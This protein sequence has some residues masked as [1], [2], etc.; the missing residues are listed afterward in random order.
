[1]FVMFPDKD[2]RLTP[3]LQSVSELHESLASFYNH[4]LKDNKLMEEQN[5][6]YPLGLR[7]FQ[8]SAAVTLQN[9]LIE[10]QAQMKVN[11][12]KYKRAVTAGLTEKVV[13]NCI[14]HKSMQLSA[15]TK[16]LR[17]TL[18]IML[19]VA[20]SEQAAIEFTKLCTREYVDS[21]N[22]E[23]MFSALAELAKNLGITSKYPN[24]FL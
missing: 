2:F 9:A 4:R 22:V 19:G 15:S 23:D 14:K 24:L 7:I 20:S 8:M 10:T 5:A 13:N 1:M 17:H 16:E 11:I 12:E 6:P 3:D 18:N 21:E